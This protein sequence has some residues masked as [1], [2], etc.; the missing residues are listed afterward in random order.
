MTGAVLE[1]RCLVGYVFTA[2]DADGRDR[3]RA[4]WA[5]ALARWPVSDR[6]G[7]APFDPAGPAGPSG[8]AVLR[9]ADG[10]PGAPGL[11]QAVLRRYRD[12]L[13]LSA[14]LSPPDGVWA[15]LMAAW[16]A[17]AAPGPGTA[18]VLTAVAPG[19]GAGAAEP[20]VRAALAAALPPGALPDGRA[21]VLPPLTHA[22]TDLLFAEA[23]RGGPRTAR[24]LAVVAP[25]GAE[26]ELDRWTWSDGSPLLAPLGRYL[27]HAAGLDLLAAA[28]DVR[29]ARA[30]T[31]V[32]R[33][34]A[35]IAAL[36]ALVRAPAGPGL[37]P[38]GRTRLIGMTGDLLDLAT[39][40]TRLAQ[41][42]RD[43]GAVAHNL[44]TAV[45]GVLPSP[46]SGD[47]AASPVTGDLGTAER[48]G[49]R[50][51]DLGAWL[52][53]VE[54]RSRYAAAAVETAVA[55]QVR[56]A[57]EAAAGLHERITTRNAAL[58]GALVMLLAAIQAMEYDVPLPKRLEPA[59]I[60]L[61]AAL[62]LLLAAA[63]P[64]RDGPTAG[65]AAH[66]APVVWAVLAT[67]AAAG[68]CVESGAG[69]VVHAAVSPARSLL[70]A[71]AAA[72]LT[73]LVLLLRTLI[74]GR[75]GAGPPIL[76]P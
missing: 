42:A 48:I 63:V 1:Q 75:R 40:R 36:L 66:G 43:A 50:A 18:V 39:L 38:A 76:G 10:A 74:R 30:R 4:L 17:V 33:V 8:D 67:A 2:D 64:G 54:E 15:D 22:P 41:D 32:G 21:V 29:T 61:L 37:I 11:H 23:A 73:G 55:E 9:I 12:R 7:G 59:L 35:H 16:Q 27:L 24:C 3:M 26:A 34:E 13:C 28:V 14:A 52:A 49:R 6:D 56:L 31:T 69:L 20:D 51:E 72:C 25:A 57:A 70:S 46:A 45:P 53:S 5:S 62:A 60:T 19:L 44:R 65:R 47:P 68:W 71:L 58:L